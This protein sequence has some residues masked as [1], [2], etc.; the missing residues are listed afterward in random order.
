MKTIRKFSPEEIIF[1][2]TTECNLHCAHCFVPR[3]EKRLSADD[4]ITFLKSCA[5]SQIEKIGFSGGEP[6][7]YPEFI[8][9]VSKAAVE[10]DFLF[11]RIMTNG[12]WWKNPAHLEKTLSD[13]YD[14]GFD[15]KTGLSWDAF[16]GQNSE[17]I[18]TFVN[19]VLTAFGTQ[20]LEIQSVI[21]PDAEKDK[22]FLE[23]LT[24]LARHLGC[25]VKKNTDK[26]T[27]RGVFILESDEIYIPVYR[28]RQSFTGDDE[29]AWKSRRWFKDDFCA[30]PG[31]VLYVHPDGNIAPCC[32]FANENK[33]LFTGTIKQPLKTVLAQAEQNEMIRI[34]YEEGLAAQIRPLKKNGALPGKTDDICAFCDFICKLR[35]EKENG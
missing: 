15:G 33:A 7:L 32:G 14:S 5:G 20:S 26:K 29:R 21:H 8:C 24:S 13:V 10:N 23:E 25:T 9:R 30:G 3:T 17:K 2:A 31:H 4:A 28:E 12:V 19:A 27:G 22:A 16:H 6:F 1:A 35:A 11:G 34:C 18:L